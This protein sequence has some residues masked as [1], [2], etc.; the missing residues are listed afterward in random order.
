MTET[1][2]LDEGGRLVLSEAALRLL[3]LKPGSQLRAN[4][5]ATGIEILPETEQEG[6]VLEVSETV[7]ENGVLVLASTG[8]KAN[9]ASAVRDERDE[10]ADRAIPR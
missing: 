8:V 1:L 2:T 6:E 10:L 9:I 3:A 5:S 4:V 7:L